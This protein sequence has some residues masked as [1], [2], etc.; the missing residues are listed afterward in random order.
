LV[1]VAYFVVL[2]ALAF[3]LQ[4]RAS[5]SLEDYFLGGRKLPWWALGVSGMAN[6]LDVAGTMVIVSLLFSLGPRGLF[7]E[8]R[9][10]AVL[11]LAV[12]MLWGGKW[13]RRSG[14]ITGAEWMIY[15]FG[16]GAGGQFARIAAAVSTLVLT[17]GMIAYLVKG[18]GLFLSLFL[19]FTPEVCAAIMIGVATAYTLMSGFY[20]V[21]ITDLFQSVVIVTAAV[22]VIGMAVTNFADNESITELAEQITEMQQ[23]GTSV[24]GTDA[25]MPAGEEYD[26][27]RNLLFLASFLVLKNLLHGVF[28]GDDPK[29]YGARN[30][31]ECGLLTFLWIWL[32]ALR[33]PMMM[34]FA[35]LGLQL[36]ADL[37]P[38]QSVVENS[39]ALI[40]EHTGAIDKDRWPELLATIAN[41]PETFSNE[42][43]E[44]LRNLL[45]EDWNRKIHLVDYA[46]TI[47]AERIL[48][49]VILFNVPLGLRGLILVALIGASMSTFDSQV[50]RAIGFFTRDI[51][52]TY[53]R[54]EA[55][56]REL[57]AASWL[58][59]LAMVG[60]GFTAAYYAT[61]INDIWTWLTIGLVGGLLVPGFL[62]FYW[63]RLNGSGFALGVFAGMFAAIGMRLLQSIQP[64]G[65]NEMWSFLENST[66]QYLISNPIG[67]FCLSVVV[68]LMGC[69]VGTYLA[70][71]TDRETLENFYRTTRPFGI[72]GPLKASVA[73]NQRAAMR[74]EH[75]YDLLALPFTLTW[76][77]TLFLLPMQLVI[78]DYQSAGVTACFFAAGLLGVYLFWYRQLPKG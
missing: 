76:Q 17:V 6:F 35:L 66:V 68:G 43:I 19:P 34:G 26:D 58:C 78:F 1:I 14:C 44:G 48:P 50:N 67:S 33:W 55:G 2:I 13:H 57:I 63:W 25:E 45:G 31:R 38:D 59:G 36:T 28:I 41:A 51:Y 64:S 49:S 22:L 23:W 75:F 46:G 52:Q 53:F 5:G 61:S 73:A 42:L 69:L 15:R 65:G 70:P 3:Y 60:L 8:F 7:I 77:I 37:F 9:G 39:A 47:N 4:K 10:G 16:K 62:K 72:W 21:V 24:P 54:P 74:R 40:R 12:A 11:V 20:G 27:Y 32:T 18:V 30:D 56:N 29:Y 71:P